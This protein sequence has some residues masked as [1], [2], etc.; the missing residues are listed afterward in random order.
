MAGTSGT[1]PPP[2]P[3]E[4]VDLAGKRQREVVS[5]AEEEDDDLYGLADSDDDGGMVVVDESDDD[6]DEPND[7]V[8]ELDDVGSHTAL[9]SLDYDDAHALVGIDVKKDFGKL[10]WFHGK[11]VSYDAAEGW[12]RVEFSDGDVLDADVG[13]LKDLLLVTSAEKKGKASSSS[14]SRKGKKKQ[15]KHHAE[16]KAKEKVTIKP[17]AFKPTI[18][19]PTKR[20]A[21][22]TDAFAPEVDPWECFN[23][24]FTA[25]M[26]AF[27]F[28][29]TTKYA[30][31]VEI[32]ERPTYIPSRYS[33]PPQWAA[34]FKSS[35]FQQK[36]FD[37]WL[38]S[39]IGLAGKGMAGGGGGPSS[40]WSSLW[41]VNIPWLKSL[42]PRRVFQLWRAALHCEDPTV[43][44]PSG[45][46]RK[47]GPLLAMFKERCNVVYIPTRDI[48]YDEATAEFGGRTTKLKHLQSRYKPFDGIRIYC[49]AEAS[50]GYVSNF[51]VDQR[52]GTTI[53]DQMFDVFTPYEGLGYNVWADNLFISV[54][55]LKRAKDLGINL[56]G[57]A[58]GGAN[59][60]FPSELFNSKDVKETGNWATMSAEPGINAYVWEDASRVRLMSNHV[61]S[62][63]S[64]VLRRKRGFKN[65]LMILA[66]LI[67]FLYNL[68]MGGVDRADAL[69]AAFTTRLKS[70]KW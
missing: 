57:T 21:I 69:R 43:P 37:V 28:K 44:T 56:A 47:V 5:Y 42:M 66:P 33:W 4:P 1:A 31:Y 13:D 61:A 45:T 9:D 2:P 65:R 7:D 17:A 14:S 49:T 39:I 70:N 19:G 54:H 48:S 35:N 38:G 22:R 16:W 11:I 59:S 58:R 46:V 53:E 40:W 62:E 10:G 8:D 63:D 27:V 32:A 64:S 68:F 29:C 20:N 36:D 23:L 25:E 67:A 34:S 52:D 41:N 30:S 3:P 26:R 55:S 60:G 6:V 51:R 15:N 18:T 12:W 24:F 50:T